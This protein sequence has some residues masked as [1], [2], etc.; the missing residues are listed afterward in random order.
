[1]TARIGSSLLAHIPALTPPLNQDSSLLKRL[2]LDQ[3]LQGRVLAVRGSQV[4]ISMLGEQIAAESLLPLQVGQVLNLVVREVQP[5]RVALH[6]A[7]KIEE[8]APGLRRIADQELSDLLSTQHLLPDRTNLLIAR[9]LLRNSLP[10]TNTI[11]L[12]ARNTLPF[13]EAPQADD[14]EA[15]IFLMLKELPV[16]HESMELAKGALLQ[17]N[18]LGARVQALVTQLVELLLHAEQI[19]P[20]GEAAILP[21][22]MLALACQLLHELPLLVPDQVQG[23][24]F[25]AL[26]KQVL[27]QIAMPTE[28]RLARLLEESM[29]T[30]RGQAVQPS[31]A[32]VKEEIII[33]LSRLSSNEG[34]DLAPLDLRPDPVK[35][36]TSTADLPAGEALLTAE[37]PQSAHSLV[38]EQEATTPAPPARLLSEEPHQ[39]SPALRRQHPSEIASDFRQQLA[40]MNDVLAQASDELPAH[41][42]LAPLLR[43]LGGAIHEMITMVEAEQ[44]SNAGMPPPT[45]P[46]GYYVF[47]LPIAVAGQ[48]TTDT[49]EVRIYYQRRGHTKR[50]DPENAHLAFLLQMSHLGPV[51]VHVDLYRKHLRCRIE[52]SNDE[53]IGLFQ[54]SS[55]ELQKRLHIVGYTV[56]SI[57]A[58]IATR[59]NTR[60]NREPMPSLFKIDIQV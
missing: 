18:N 36:M 31:T 50:V 43:E 15:A 27:N 30:L 7:S 45:Q 8:E 24:A 10:I 59:L 12:A 25:A 23:Q 41:H 17:P 53:T 48:D 55:F 13:I 39:A 58:L 56:D 3:A 38:L 33:E 20:G 29:H 1:M 21:R 11:V 35:T 40:S 16:T 49:A 44:L 47:N 6:V 42:R 26:V 46:Q 9:A 5:D 52:C 32:P 4:V 57:R 22:D 14:I 37:S 51:D 2:N 34:L 54:E 28:H 19:E 60:S